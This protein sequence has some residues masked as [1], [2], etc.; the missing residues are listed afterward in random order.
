MKSKKELDEKQ[1]IAKLKAAQEL[2]KSRFKI[3]KPVSAKTAF[4]LIME[5][6]KE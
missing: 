1:E 6:C 3:G 4:K 5:V 2:V